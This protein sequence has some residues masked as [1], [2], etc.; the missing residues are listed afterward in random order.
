M[1]CIYGNREKHVR[2]NVA[3]TCII[4]C[5]VCVCLCFHLSKPFV[6]PSSLGLQLVNTISLFC[7]ILPAPLR[8]NSATLV[9][10]QEIIIFGIK[11]NYNPNGNCCVA[12]LFNHCTSLVATNT[13]GGFPLSF[14]VTFSGSNCVGYSEGG[15]GRCL[16]RLW[17]SEEKEQ[18]WA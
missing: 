14:F 7:I 15:Q 13:P 11:M 3:Y 6:C 16:Q 9:V 12:A 17:V 10:L 4:I 2:C 18:L 8:P 1:R 5:T